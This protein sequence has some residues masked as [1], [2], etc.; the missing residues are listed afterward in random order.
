MSRGFTLLETI[1]GCAIIAIASAALLF[2]I[3]GAARFSGE[4]ASGPAHTA[5]QTLA[6][7][8]MHDLQTSW[9]YGSPGSING[10]FATSLPVPP[11]T[12]PATVRVSSSAGG[13][14]TITVTVVYTPDPNHQDSGTVSIAAPATV[15]GP[16]PG[17]Q[18]SRPG[19]IPDP[20]ATPTP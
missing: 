12:S 17:S 15:R 19:L 1:V 2:A 8:T 16:L 5:A 18:V 14:T 3:G 9:K 10:G 20:S 6:Q 11:G 13:L 7:S 4:S